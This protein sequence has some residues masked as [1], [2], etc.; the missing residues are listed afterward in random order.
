MVSGT[1]TRGQ[2]DLTQLVPA[3]METVRFYDSK[4]EGISAEIFDGPVSTPGNRISFRWPY[5]VDT[6]RMAPI[7]KETTPAVFAEGDAYMDSFFT[8]IA[9]T[10]WKMEPTMWDSEIGH[11]KMTMGLDFKIQQA[12]QALMRRRDYEALKYAFG[13]ASTIKRYS[14][15]STDRMA[16]W[17][18]TGDTDLTAK[19]W[20]DT[21][22][23]DILYDLDVIL[24]NSRLIGDKPMKKM[25]IGPWTFFNMKQNATLAD[26]MVYT[27]D[28]RMEIIGS[29]LRG[30]SLKEIVYARYKENSSY[31]GVVGAPGLGSLSYDT[32]TTMK[33]QH[34]MKHTVSGTTYEFGFITADKV[35]TMFKAPVYTSPGFPTGDDVTNA[36]QDPDTLVKYA[37]RAIRMGFAVPDW[38]DIHKLTRVAAF[39]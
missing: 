12:S 31:S 34:M 23:A 39:A 11:G 26:E 10:G 4:Y 18:I 13:D 29:E 25:I 30:L 24:Y 37:W 8:K 27:H 3:Y 9:K 35:G 19:A 5:A 28:P 15:Q 1:E 17:D 20:S 33:S 36:W 32:W 2:V 6:G 16:E 21:A 7:A 22:N 14:T 38:A